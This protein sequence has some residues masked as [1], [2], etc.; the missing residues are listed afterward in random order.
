MGSRGKRQ[1]ELMAHGFIFRNLF[2]GTITTQA[3]I[4]FKRF[5]STF[6]WQIRKIRKR[7]CP[8]DQTLLLS[9][10]RGL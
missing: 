9:G 2:S 8:L 7:V 10:K 4:D 6:A 3:A 1:P 5:N